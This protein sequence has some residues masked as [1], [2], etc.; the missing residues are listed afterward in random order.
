MHFFAINF[1]EGCYQSDR[2]VIKSIRLHYNNMLPWMINT[3]IKVI[4][5]VR[6]PRAILNSQ[7]GLV[8]LPVHLIDTSIV[9][10]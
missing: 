7:L 3:D 5:L 10:Q 4:Q 1:S 2:I 6:D 8:I 9:Q